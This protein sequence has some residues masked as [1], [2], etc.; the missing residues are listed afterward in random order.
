M[1]CLRLVKRGITK[2]AKAKADSKKYR[3]IIED[4]LYEYRTG[5]LLTYDGEIVKDEKDALAIALEKA[6][7]Y[8]D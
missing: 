8:K 5:K 4:V 1:H 3:Q 6:K 2:M 7:A